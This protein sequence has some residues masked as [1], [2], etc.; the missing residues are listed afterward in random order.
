M[1]L[2]ERSCEVIFTYVY[3]LLNAVDYLL[4]VFAVGQSRGIPLPG[5]TFSSPTAQGDRFLEAGFTS[6]GGKSLTEI[7]KEVVSASE[8]E[9]YVV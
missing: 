6:C 3:V 8:L 2:L 5:A 7:R 9:R 1:I 4:K